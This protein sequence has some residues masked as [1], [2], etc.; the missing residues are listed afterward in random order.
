MSMIDPLSLA[1]GAAADTPAGAAPGGDALAAVLRFHHESQ[2]HFS[3]YARSPGQLDWP[4]Q[5]APFRRY[6]GCPV[7][8]LPP[9][10]P[11]R[12]SVGH[13]V[14]DARL[15]GPVPSVAVAAHL[16]G[17]VRENECSSS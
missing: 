15:A 7:I 2:H 16:G 1:A 4:N 13:P 14:D 3:R 11:G 17:N 9:P 6:E 8:A 12:I 10:T 5:P